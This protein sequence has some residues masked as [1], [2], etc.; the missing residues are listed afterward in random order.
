MSRLLVAEDDPH[1]RT[2]VVK[3]L[4]A[5]GFAV[6]AVASGKA[7]L[8]AVA[9]QD[10]ALLV[11]DLGLPDMDGITVLERLRAT[12]AR[13][14]VIILS[15]RAGTRDRVAGLDGGADDYLTKPFELAELLARV[16]TRLRPQEA[17]RGEVLEAHGISLDLTTRWATI[18]ERRIEL[19]LREFMVLETLM[20]HPDQ[21]MSR[22]QLLS[23]AWGYDFDPR[24]N[25]VDVY[26]GYLRR[27]LGAQR[28]ETVRGA[29]YRLR[30]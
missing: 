28:I 15:G 17:A 11:L 6:D 20:R 13:L 18:A 2:F 14:P 3:G 24:S 30:G 23:A 16:R 5:G 19:S 8:A 25:V 27:K 26:I 10:Y 4:G 9:E 7:V 22:Q 29:G 1:V 12:G 21:V